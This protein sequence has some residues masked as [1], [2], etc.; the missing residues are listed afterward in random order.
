MAPYSTICRFLAHLETPRLIKGALYK[1][2]L[3]CQK[4]NRLSAM[5]PLERDKDG[6]ILVATD[7]IK[8]TT[9]QGAV[10]L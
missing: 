2:L 6:S 5:D 3:I 8:T 1:M 7:N 9:P 4:T 10:Y